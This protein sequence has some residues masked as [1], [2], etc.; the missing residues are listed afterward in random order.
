MPLRADNPATAVVVA[1]VTGIVTVSLTVPSHS[2]QVSFTGNVINDFPSTNPDVFI[3]VDQLLIT[4]RGNPSGWQMTDVRY[5]YDVGTDT[6]YFGTQASASELLVW[7]GVGLTPLPLPPSC[8]TVPLTIA[9][10]I[11]PWTPRV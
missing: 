7:M 9:H 8:H 3:S 4:Y 5:A 6:A 2:L 10:V 1:I 11:P